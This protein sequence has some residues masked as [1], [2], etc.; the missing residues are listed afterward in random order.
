MKP[1]IKSSRQNHIRLNMMGAILISLGMVCE[2]QAQY[3]GKNKV[4]YDKFNFRVIQTEHFR[5]FYYPAEVKTAEESADM[6]ERWYLRE[7]GIFNVEFPKRSSVVLYANQADF[8]QTEVISGLISQGTGGVTESM[9]QRIVMPMTGISSEND[10]VLGHELTHVFQYTIMKN[11]KS[12]LS[13]DASVPL[14]FIEGMAEYLSLG[15]I[16]TLTSMWLR[17]AVL[18]KKKMPGI[19]DLDGNPDYFPYRWGH[20]LWAYLGGTYGDDKISP[21]FHAVIDTGWAEGFKEALHISLDSLSD[22]WKQTIT[23]YYK[24]Q[25]SG[26]TLPEKIGKS[27]ITGQGKMNLSPEISPD[28]KTLAYLS[29]RD[30]FSVDLYLAD[31][32]TG[33]VIK[34]LVNTVSNPHFDAMRFIDASGAWSPDG[35]QFAFVVFE[36]GDNAIAFVNIAS[37]QIQGRRRFRSLTAIKHITW[38][39]D[40]NALM[41]FGTQGGR[42][43]LFRYDITAD[44][45]SAVTNDRYAEI[46]PDWSPDGKQ[47]VFATDRGPDTH[48]DKQEYG[49][50]QIE[51]M[52]LRTGDVERISLGDHVRHSCPRF[53]PDGKSIV[54]LA[55][56]DGF[57]DIYRYWIEEKRFERL[58]RCATGIS[59]LTDLSPAL[60]VAKQTGKLAFNVFYNAGYQIHAIDPDTLT[61]ID[62]IPQLTD[63]LKFAALPPEHLEPVQRVPQYMHIAELGLPDSSRFEMT[64][65]KPDIRLLYVGQPVIGI[66]VDRFG[67]G[68]AGGISML[69]GDMLN[70]NLINLDLQV[71]GTFKDIGG[72]LTYL[73]QKN[74]ID[75]GVAAAHIPY[76]TGLAYS[77]YD[78]LRQNSTLYLAQVTD[79][80]TQRIF[81]DQ[82]TFLAQYPLSLNRRIEWGVGFDH[83]SY[84]FEL[85]RYYTTLD[86]YYLQ[87]KKQNV[88]A[89]DP[90]NLYQTYA[91]YVGDYSQFG[92][93]SPTVGMRYRLDVEPTFGSFQYYSVIADYRKYFFFR[94][95]TLAFRAL[96]LGR[97]GR[98]AEDNQLTSYFLGYETLVRGYEL[99]NL[100]PSECTDTGD[101]GQCPEFA[102]LTGSRVGILNAEIRL[103]LFGVE[104]YGLINFRYLPT[105]IS[106]FVDGGVAWNRH[107]PPEWSFKQRSKQRIPVFSAGMALRVNLFGYV[108]AQVYY[109]YPFQRP[110][111]G[112]HFGFVLAPG[113]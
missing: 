47:I 18:H 74:R 42:G 34:K 104:Q 57:A 35:R 109:V 20:A 63:K 73:N 9:Q 86:G 106:A 89:P 96:H 62:S 80:L 41:I 101:T 55:D 10:H 38:S 87:R 68:V 50:T 12:R 36:H 27:L 16:S 54:F 14:W 6:L 99:S 93:T 94:P 58:T 67:T 113:W 51:L 77:G 71:N 105:E 29:L 28:G 31:A 69:F 97:Y 88:S 95:V 102:R 78:T 3:F 17:D 11:E 33:R 24:N 66:A 85:E 64:N 79:L 23:A 65:Y 44:T 1:Y 39:P 48:P 76:R 60:S 100:D 81:S 83:I 72:Q 90:L 30:V 43:N 110:E 13:E 108:I 82:L 46:H 92:F 45:L 37:R 15:R 5:V 56:A 107:D 112:A 98:D 8:Q 25:V 70:R 52:T 32:A 91:A 26:R 75:W 84:D 53:M 40:G 103:P 49:E 21:L 111:K 22:N 4:V 19:N 59:G 2:L 7:A 61:P